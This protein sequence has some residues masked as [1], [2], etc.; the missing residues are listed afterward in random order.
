MFRVLI[1]ATTT[2]YQT[3][4]FGD[5]AA[6]LGIELIFATDRCHMLEDPWRDAAIAI[7]F[8]DEASSVQAILDASARMR[9]DGVVAVGDRPTVVAARVGE[10]VGLP[11]HGSDAAAA[12]RTK[13]LTRTRFRAAGLLVPAFAQHPVTVDPLAIANT[14]VYPAVVKP[15]ALSGS[16]GVVRVDD[17]VELAA[18]LA[19]LRT[20]LASP[21]VRAERDPAHDL[22]LI[23]QFVDGKEFAVEGVLNH[24]ELHVL[25]VF[26]KPDP[27]DG[28][29]FEETIYVTPSRAP[30][31]IQAA[32]TD[33][34][35]QAASAL[36]LCHGPIHAE[37]RVNA[38]GVFVLEVAARPIGGLCARALRLV[39]GQGALAPPIALEE[40]LLRHALGETS[41]SWEREAA[42]SAVMM[43]PIPRR[44]IF[45][46]VEGVDAA[47]AVRGIEDIQVTAKAGQVLVPL[48]EGATYLGFIFARAEGPVIAEAAIRAA[49]ARLEITILPEVRVLQSRHG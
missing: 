6:R 25:A 4:A 32:I 5:A 43:I 48:P 7:R 33:A 35:A 14:V 36:G 26:D 9:I 18:A 13:H 10:A 15:L 23:E 38:R 30:A 12:A 17:H 45:N 27:L 47:R 2:G 31:A 24:G 34:V 44:G 1:L 20:L 3:R 37:C 49:H 46:G 16:R 8:S 39:P 22:V 29:F 19:R 41:T 21:D 28:P 11:W 40:L 42:A